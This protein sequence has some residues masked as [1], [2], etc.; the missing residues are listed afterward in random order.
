VIVDKPIHFVP[1]ELRC[2]RCFGKDIVPSI[3]RGW[4]DSLMGMLG[5]IPRQCRFCEKRFYA[6]SAEFVG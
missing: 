1:G 2:P 4:L 3:A 6:S 5:R